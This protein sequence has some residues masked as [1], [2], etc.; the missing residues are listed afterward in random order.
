MIG[1]FMRTVR[2]L[3]QQQQQQQPPGKSVITLGCSSEPANDAVAK[4]TDLSGINSDKTVCASPSH[5][6]FIIMFT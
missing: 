5:Y 3:T 6:I 1:S 4:A 2:V